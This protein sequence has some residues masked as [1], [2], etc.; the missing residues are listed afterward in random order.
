MA[1]PL[2]REQVRDY[3][4]QVAAKDFDAISDVER[5]KLMARFFADRV[6]RVLNPSLVPSTDEEMNAAAIDGSDDCG[7]DFMAHEGDAVTIIQAKYSGHKKK[8]EPSG[9]IERSLRIVQLGS[10]SPLPGTQAG[11]DEPQVE[12]GRRG[13]RLGK[14]YLSA[15]L[16]KLET[17]WRECIQARRAGRCPCI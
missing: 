6:L 5:S 10:Q 2:F 15:I 7:V 8:R 4:S 11:Q 3:A 14:R 1:K 12:G 17:G 16:H 9:G 13:Y